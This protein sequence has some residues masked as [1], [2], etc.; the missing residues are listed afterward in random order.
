MAY[1]SKY[2]QVLDEIH[3]QPGSLSLS[4]VSFPAPES[5]V[6]SLPVKSYIKND[7]SGTIDDM[8]Q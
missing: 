5:V 4:M 7:A 1:D 8:E 2:L 3:R 6:N